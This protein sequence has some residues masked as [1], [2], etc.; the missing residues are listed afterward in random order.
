MTTEINYN[1]QTLTTDEA[2]MLVYHME[3]SLGILTEDYTKNINTYKQDIK[4]TQSLRRKLL[5]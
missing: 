4:L 2:L 1:T 5:Q 3:K